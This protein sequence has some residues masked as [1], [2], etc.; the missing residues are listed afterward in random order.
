MTNN[1]R[2]EVSWTKVAPLLAVTVSAI[3]AVLLSILA[4][5]HI[6]LGSS[7]T[8]WIT[9]NRASTQI[10]VQLLSMTLGTFQLYAFQSLFRFWISTHLTRKSSSLD[11]L[12]F[13]NAVYAARFDH[14]IQLQWV[15]VLLLYLAAVQVP[16]ALWAGALTPV[17]ASMEG[18][19]LYTIPAYSSSTENLW[20]YTCWPTANCPAGF[21]SAIS[22]PNGTFTYIPW[23]GEYNG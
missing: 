21:N 6:H 2:I 3:V 16:A 14:E 23:K 8:E 18:N 15:I 22:T 5:K 13:M 10:I 17:F 1:T 20:G 4:S 7:Q 9:Q 19:A 12:K 11:S